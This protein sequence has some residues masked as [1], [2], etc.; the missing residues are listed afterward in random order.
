M[1]LLHHHSLRPPPLPIASP[2][3]H[4]Y[5]SLYYIVACF[6]IRYSVASAQ[7]PHRK[8]TRIFV[9]CSCHLPLATPPVAP[10]PSRSHFAPPCACVSF[11]AASDGCFVLVHTH[12]PLHNTAGGAVVIAPEYCSMCATQTG[13]KHLLFGLAVLLPFIFSCNRRKCEVIVS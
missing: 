5:I 4:L 1:S 6:S 9:F 7:K 13:R 11:L 12:F 8:V 2:T 10:S 3:K